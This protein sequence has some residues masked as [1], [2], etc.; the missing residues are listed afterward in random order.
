[1]STADVYYLHQ[2]VEL[3]RFL[4]EAHEIQLEHVSVVGWI[5]QPEQYCSL[6][7]KLC[8]TACSC[9]EDLE[10]ACLVGI[11]HLRCRR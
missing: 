9:T 11:G 3:L 4:D 10:C 6:V 1:V 7:A 8:E 2:E 5:V